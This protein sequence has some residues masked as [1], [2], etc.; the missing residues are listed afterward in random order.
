L[1]TISDEYLQSLML[2]DSPDILKSFPPPPPLP[3][4][5]SFSITI[6]STNKPR[7]QTRNQYAQ[8]DKFP[9][10][11]SPYTARSHTLPLV[12]PRRQNAHALTISTAP[13]PE[14]CP[15]D[16]GGVITELK[17]LLLRDAMPYHLIAQRLIAGKSASTGLAFGGDEARKMRVG[18]EARWLGMVRL[19]DELSDGR[20]RHRFRYRA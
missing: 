11:S 20:G 4:P 14:P 7:A 2:P 13:V 3:L 16:G 12:M 9:S 17:I 6:P 8:Q 5:E 19:A 18:E 1:L 15:K 10:P